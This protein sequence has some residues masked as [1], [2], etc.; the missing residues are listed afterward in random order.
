MIDLGLWVTESY[1]VASNQPLSESDIETVIKEQENK[2]Y[3]EDH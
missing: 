2:A 3:G 1:T